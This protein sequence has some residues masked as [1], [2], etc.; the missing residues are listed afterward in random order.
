MERI[1][2]GLGERSYA[3]VLAEDFKGLGA[4]AAKV[5]LPGRCFLVSNSTVGPLYAEPC[6]E[7]LRSAGFQPDV[8]LL[9]DGEVFK[10]LSV[11]EGLVCELLKRGADRKSPVF[12]LGG[13]VIGDI[14]GFA[15]ATTLRGIPFIQLPTSLLAM[16]DA[17]VGGKTGV[18]TPEGKN[19]IGAFYQP[20]L[21]WAG[22]HSLKTLPDAELR[23]GF[24]EMIKHQLISGELA[25]LEEQAAALK[26]R[27][28]RALAT[29][30]AAS[31]RTKAAVVEKDEREEG[32]R[33]ILNLGH[34]LGHAIEAVS[35][36][37]V[38]AHG[39][40][41]GLG[42]LAISGYARARGLLESPAP[43][44]LW[45]D[46]RLSLLTSRLGLPIKI[47][48]I[49]LDTPEIREA[50]ARAAGF[51]KKRVRG[52]LTIVV[53]RAPGRVVLQKVSIDEVPALVDALMRLG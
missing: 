52:M 28:P 21:V 19:L 12:A 6:C 4:E 7:E 33:A 44:E 1:E 50:L 3:V 23:C 36:F 51:D 32:L 49:F 29:L 22:L 11:W 13:G 18:N 25:Q 48:G 31:I 39:E 9:P 42:L 10:T 40:A 20:L 35:G 2:L 15:A 5:V 17:S 30:V 24:G 16:V 47:S 26:A 27:D 34:T 14:V 8:I 53:P 43:E 38:V 45:L 37:G 41:V 46:Q